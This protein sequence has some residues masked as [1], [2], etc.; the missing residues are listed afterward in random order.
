MAA[1]AKYKGELETTKSRAVRAEAEAAAL[2]EE[3]A[4][5]KRRQRIPSREPL[6]PVS[7]NHG[8]EMGSSMTPSMAPPQSATKKAISRAAL[9]AASS[10]LNSKY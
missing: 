7:R 2:R 9:T 6:S 5:I 4:E 3:L 8:S 1:V 10:I